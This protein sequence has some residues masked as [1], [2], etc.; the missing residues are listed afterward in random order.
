MINC[1]ADNITTTAGLAAL[2]AGF[3]A[4]TTV[5][6][7]WAALLLVPAADRGLP[8]SARREALSRARRLVDGTQ[9]ILPHIKAW[10]PR[11][12]WLPLQNRLQ[13][14]DQRVREVET[15]GRVQST[16]PDASV[17]GER[18]GVFSEKACAADPS[19]VL[20]CRDTPLT[21]GMA[22]GLV[23]AGTTATANLPT[24]ASCGSPAMVLRK[25]SA[26]KQVRREAGC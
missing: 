26:C 5:M 24:C 16:T 21:I 2:S 20:C 1:L 8:A 3:V 12:T 6:G 11:S 7:H 9:A 25:C 23:G 17:G 22:C 14:L 10:A 19:A 13:W 15:T 4:A 18:A